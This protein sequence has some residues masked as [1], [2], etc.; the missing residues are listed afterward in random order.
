MLFG[1]VL[2]LLVHTLMPSADPHENLKLLWTHIKAE[3]AANKTASKFG[4]M[5]MTM[6]S[7]KG[8]AKLRGTAAVIKD[9]GPV[10]YC[11]FKRYWNSELRLHKLIELALRS[12]NHLETILER[13]KQEFV[14]SGLSYVW[15]IVSQRFVAVLIYGMS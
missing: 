9:F 11:I 2:H 8:T 6:F 10:V 5:K 13:N 1:S 15:A 4:V 3:Y 14:L 12:G 7:P